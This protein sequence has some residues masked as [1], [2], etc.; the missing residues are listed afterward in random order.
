MLHGGPLATLFERP[1]LPTYTL[2]SALAESYGGAVGFESPRV[3]ANFVSSVDGVVALSEGGESGHVISRGSEADRFVM[4]MLRACADTVLV[5]AGTFRRGRGHLW[6]AEVIFP[7]AAEAF[8]EL[9]KSLG[10]AAFPRFVVVTRSGSIDTAEPAL[11][12]ALVVTSRA[13]EAALRSRVSSSTRVVA[14]GADTVL[15]SDVVALLMREGTRTLL[16][17][18]GPS[19]FAEMVRDQLIDEL[20]LTKSPTLFGRFPN[21]RRKSL[22]DG[23]DLNGTPMELLSLK[24]HGSYL[25]SRYELR[26]ARR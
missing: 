1:G 20:F 6:R 24:R 18:G 11:E 15:L 22:T 13:A 21:D 5:G 17:E 2:P 14:L 25:F 12:G 8:A 19:L 16:T 10:L 23:I 4:G 3:L 9:R 26:S 7:D